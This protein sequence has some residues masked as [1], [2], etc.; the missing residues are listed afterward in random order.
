M[1]YGRCSSGLPFVPRPSIAEQW[2]RARRRSWP[3]AVATSTPPPPAAASSSPFSAATPSAI[4]A[5]A[6]TG[7]WY[8]GLAGLP[9]DARNARS[10]WLSPPKRLPRPPPIAPPSSTAAPPTVPPSP[11]ATPTAKRLGRCGRLAASDRPG[12]R[13]PATSL[14]GVGLSA[15][16]RPSQR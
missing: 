1:S 12:P 10:S 11:P 8:A 7:L 14:A 16:A 15:V 5:D 6:F 13:S 2:S 3:V 9:R 4:A